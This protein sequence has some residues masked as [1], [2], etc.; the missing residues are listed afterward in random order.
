MCALAFTTLPVLFLIYLPGPTQVK[1]WMWPFCK[2]ILGEE[3]PSSSPAT[4]L[5]VWQKNIML[6][7]VSAFEMRSKSNIYDEDMTDLC[8]R[9]VQTC[10]N[11]TR[12]YFR[13]P[14]HSLP[15][16]PIMT[17]GRHLLQ[18]LPVQTFLAAARPIRIARGGASWSPVWNCAA[19]ETEATC[20]NSSS[21]WLDTI[22]QQKT[23][24]SELYY[25]CTQTW[26]L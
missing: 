11:I 15:T 16:S 5:L 12:N 6:N 1:L 19:V 8:R 20:R 18:R 9:K 24:F 2:G 26:T 13:G 25:T 7:N 4:C 21:T 14:V 17:T 10:A 23:V 3:P 22:V